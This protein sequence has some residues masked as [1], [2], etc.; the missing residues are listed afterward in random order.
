MLY[1][2]PPYQLSDLW[3]DGQTD[4]RQDVNLELE[5]SSVLISRILMRLQVY[6]T[7]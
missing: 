7:L 6:F 1:V 4:G 3:V 2:G 5:I